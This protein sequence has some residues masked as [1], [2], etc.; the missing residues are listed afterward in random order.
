M[1]IDQL[2]AC[3]LDLNPELLNGLPRTQ[4]SQGIESKMLKKLTH[5]Q[6]KRE[7]DEP[8]AVIGYLLQAL[9][10]VHIADRFGFIRIHS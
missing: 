3:I 2:I 10:Y 9:D 1:F 7:R 6:V 8:F 5:D 4:Q